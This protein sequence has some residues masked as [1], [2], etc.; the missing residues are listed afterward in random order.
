MKP[1]LLARIAERALKIGGIPGGVGGETELPIL[2]GGHARKE[3]P[4]WRMAQRHSRV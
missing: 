4:R 3:V 2:F 1:H